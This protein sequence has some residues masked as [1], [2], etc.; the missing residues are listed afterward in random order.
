V[1]DDARAAIEAKVVE[2]LPEER[3][4]QWILGPAYTLTPIELE[5][6]CTLWIRGRVEEPI[7]QMARITRSQE[8]KKELNRILALPHLKFKEEKPASAPPN[9]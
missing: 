3:Q 2:S 6:L 9:G 4:Y 7:R 1:A 5:D 8:L